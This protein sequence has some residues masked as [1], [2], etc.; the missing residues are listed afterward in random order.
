LAEFKVK[1]D[2]KYTRAMSRILDAEDE[3]ERS[4]TA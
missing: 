4:L 1:R 2:D 3:R